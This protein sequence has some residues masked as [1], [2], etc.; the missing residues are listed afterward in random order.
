MRRTGVLI[1]GLALCLLACG[2][3]VAAR[4]ALPVVYSGAAADLYAVGHINGSPP[5]ANDFS[6][7]P[8]S[9]H[10]YPVV[11]VHGT[12]ENMAYNWYT[13]SPL[14]RNAGYCVFALNYGQEAGKVVD[15]PGA[16]PGGDGDI[17]ASAGELASFVDRVLSATGSAQVDIVGHSQGGMMP[18]Y[19]MRFLGG[20]ERVHALVG[21]SPSNLGTTVDGLINLLELAGATELGEGALA[22]VC[23]PSCEQLVGG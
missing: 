18:R 17:R 20:A 5:G 13:L 7:R 2:G 6:C 11:L 22:T 15:L 16:A 14:L 9:A 23:G 8:T 19:Y 12:L 10:P 1:V 21:L 3:A 4:A